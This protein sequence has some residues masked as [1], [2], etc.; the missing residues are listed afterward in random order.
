MGAKQAVLGFR[1]TLA[2]NMAAALQ[3]VRHAIQHNQFEPRRQTITAAQQA[4]PPTQRILRVNIRVCAQ[5]VYFLMVIQALAK[6]NV[7]GTVGVD[8][9][10]DPVRVD[11]LE[12]M[13]VPLIQD[14][15]LS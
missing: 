1:H 2:D 9:L 8:L 7:A 15:F 6:G 3:L 13:V 14:G 11:W 12:A 10:A 5:R 4:T